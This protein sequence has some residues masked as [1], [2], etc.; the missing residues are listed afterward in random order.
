MFFAL[1]LFLATRH[2]GF[3]AGQ[4]RIKVSQHGDRSLTLEYPFKM[5]VAL[6]TIPHPLLGVEYRLQAR[7]Q[8]ILPDSLIH[9]FEWRY[10]QRPDGQSRRN[11]TPDRIIGRH[12]K[13]SFLFR[14]LCCFHASTFCSCFVEVRACFGAVCLVHIKLLATILLLRYK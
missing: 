6:E 5:A 4:Y 12:M 10:Y 9:R 1:Q 14:Y 3:V 8:I 2:N 13:V 7:R 11:K